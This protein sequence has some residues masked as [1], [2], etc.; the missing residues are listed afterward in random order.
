VDPVKITVFNTELKTYKYDDSE[1]KMDKEDKPGNFIAYNN[2]DDDGDDVQDK[3]DGDGVT[4]ENDLQKV[5]FKFGGIF[6]D[7]FDKGKVVIERSNSK[8]KLWRQETKPSG[9]EITFTANKKTYD[10]SNSTQRTAFRNEIRNK[11]LYVEGYDKSGSVRDTEF[12]LKYVDPSDVDICKDPVKYTIVKIDLDVNRNGNT[13]DAVDEIVGYDPGY[14]GSVW[15]IIGGA[16][17]TPQRMDILVEPVD[18]TI[19]NSV[20]LTIQDVTKEVGYC[21]NAGT[22]P[23]TEDDYSFLASGND[24]VETGTISGG[25][26]TVL[27]VCKDYGAFCNLKTE[28]KQGSDVLLS[29]TRPIPSDTNLNRIP[30]HWTDDDLPNTTANWDAENTPNHGTTGDGLGRYEEY[31]GFIINGTTH[32]RTRAREK[33]LFIYRENGAYGAE[34]VDDLATIHFITADEMNGAHH[35]NEHNGEGTIRTA[36]GPRIVNFNYG[37]FGHVVAQHG[38][39]LDV[40]TDGADNPAP[41]SRWGICYDNNGGEAGAIGSPESAGRILVR[42]QNIIDSCGPRAG[43]EFS[44][45]AQA[46]ADEFIKDTIGHEGAHGVSVVHHADLADIPVT[47][48]PGPTW[49]D[50]NNKNNYNHDR[51]CEAGSVTCVTRYNFFDISAAVAG[52]LDKNGTPESATD[53][54]WTPTV[55][56][57]TGYCNPCL[58]QIDISD[59]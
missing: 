48:Y 23:N 49:L 33:D 44:Y 22:Q 56:V 42:A 10:L 52:D 27:F 36:V 6:S 5:H 30:D 17:F 40:S 8:L 46:R 4:N 34:D 19:V 26:A 16:T 43:T 2:D 15:K 3:G 21:M 1:L 35:D 20:A 53:S 50:V 58:A 47:D 25:K 7:S 54:D 41:F 9:S 37:T 59:N 11:D 32:T 12:T 24:T 51:S 18:G 13:D 39:W 31:R 14:E 57:C 55:P 45:N 38:L 28:L 29:W